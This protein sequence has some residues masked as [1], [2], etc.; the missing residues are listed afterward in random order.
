[1]IRRSTSYHH[2]LQCP[3]AWIAHSDGIC[4]AASSLSTSGV[5]PSS[6]AEMRKRKL[7]LCPRGAA[8][9]KFAAFDVTQAGSLL[10]RR[11]A[12]GRP[13]YF[14]IHAILNLSPFPNIAI[15]VAFKLPKPFYCLPLPSDERG[16][17]EG[18]RLTN[19]LGLECPRMH[20]HLWWS[21]LRLCLPAPAGTR[22]GIRRSASYH[23]GLQHPHFTQPPAAF[24]PGRY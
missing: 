10:C 15:S 6:G 12:V 13:Q 1:V 8:R 24:R 5:R 7:A 21:R 11:L 2:G 22:G 17:G 19:K 9:T 14:Q 18:N 23:H 16:R 20:P 3:I 4:R